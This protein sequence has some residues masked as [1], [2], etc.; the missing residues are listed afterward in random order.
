[1][2]DIYQGDELHYLAL[3]DPD[4]RRPV[5]WD[6]RQA[7]LRRL[8]GGSR[9]DFETRKMFLI[10]RLLGLR[11]RRPRAFVG[12][13]YEPLDAGEEACA[14][15]RGDDVLVVVAVRGEVEG[16]TFEAPGGRWRD[17]LRGDEHSFDGRCRLTDVLGR[18][19][20]GVFERL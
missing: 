10:L 11:G 8:M 6:W 9:P 19:G 1:V 12:A 7:M 20:F 13:G 3:V 4:N 15:L 16:A 5:D 17:V 2:P 18:F 14:F